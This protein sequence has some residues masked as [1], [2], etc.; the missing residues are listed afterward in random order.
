MPTPGRSNKGMK[1]IFYVFAQAVAVM[2]GCWLEEIDGEVVFYGTPEE[3]KFVISATLAV[4][5]KDIISRKSGG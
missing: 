4:M 1:C 3:Q 2:I 5:S